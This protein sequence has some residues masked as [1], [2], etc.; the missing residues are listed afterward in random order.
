MEPSIKTVQLVTLSGLALICFAGNSLLCRMALRSGSIDP[1]TFTVV[2]LFSGA[3]ILF[4]LVGVKHSIL[5][6]GVG[7]SWKSGIALF[8]YAAGFSW[9][10]INLTVATGALILFGC[11]QG[12]MIVSAY[13]K[14]ERFGVRQALGCVLAIVGLVILLLPGL[15]APAPVSAMFMAMA[16]VSWGVYSLLGKTFSN[17]LVATAGSFLRALPFALVMGLMFLSQV[18]ASSYGVMLAFVSGVFTSGLGYAVWYKVLSHIKSSTAAVVQ[19]CVPVLAALGGVV[20][21][22]EVLTVRMVV[23]AVLTLLGIG[24]VVLR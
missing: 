11:V 7:G 8:V 20:L 16:G 2:R 24:M 21:L 6:C 13:Y 12:T 19:L 18:K 1:A 23:S 5:S 3:I 4:V 9:A 10:Y 15:A 17:P 14:G 22:G